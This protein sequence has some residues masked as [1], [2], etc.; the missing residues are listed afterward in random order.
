M[1]EGERSYSGKDWA[2]GKVGTVEFEVREAGEGREPLDEG[3]Q[4]IIGRGE[5][6]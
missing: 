5:D 3:D 2:K 1:F 6:K 4:S